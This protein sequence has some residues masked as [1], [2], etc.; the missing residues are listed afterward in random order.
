VAE[1]EGVACEPPH[2]S[3]YPSIVKSAVCFFS[4]NGIKD[5]FSR[6]RMARRA[7]ATDAT[8]W[9]QPAVASR[10]RPRPGL[11]GAC[12]PF[13]LPSRPT[14]RQLSSRC[15]GDHIASARA[16]RVITITTTAKFTYVVN[17]PLTGSAHHRSRSEGTLRRFLS[18]LTHHHHDATVRQHQAHDPHQSLTR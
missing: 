1:A 18:P 11:S 6:T 14:M 9:L 17:F 5:G 8:H 4:V 7:G 12:Q 16:H 13:H 3:V 2:Q 10:S 15:D